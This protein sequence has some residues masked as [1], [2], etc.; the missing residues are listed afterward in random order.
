[1]RQEQQPAAVSFPKQLAALCLAASV[2][3]AA[4]SHER[5][6]GG[7]IA[8]SRPQS[9][10]VSV[11]SA[12]ANANPSARAGVMRDAERTGAEGYDRIEENGFT[13]VARAPLSTFS[14]DVD[15]ASYS[16]TRRFLTQ[17]QLPPADA[18]RVEEFINYF[19]YDYPQPQGGQPFSVS[20]E[21]ADCPW[22]PQHKLVQIGLQG[23]RVAAEDL[24]PSNLVFL[25]DVS[26]SMNHPNRL[27]LVKS[28]LRLLAEQ[29]SAR[30]RVAMVVYAGS[31]GLVLP[32]TP[33]DR[34]GE[35]LSAIDQLEAGGSTNG[36]EG[37]RLAYRVA[38]E[39]F[40]QGGINRVILATDGDFNVGVTSDDEL[41]RLVEERRQGGVSLSVL[42]YGMGNL[43]DS[44]MEKLADKGDG[45]YA[46][47]DTLAEARKVLG[48]Q[49]G[50]TLYTI[51]KDV[52]IQVEFNPR[53]VAGYRL[54][55]YE[56][57]LLRD[58]DFNDDGVDAGEIGAGHTV[59]ALYEIVPAGQRVGRGV[60]PLKY[61]KGGEPST[62]AGG[63]ELLT[64]KLRYKEPEQRDSKLLSTAVVDTRASHRNASDNFKFAA[65]VA[66]F[67][68]LLRD[69]PHKGEATYGHAL[70]LARA[71]T[72]ADLRGHRTEFVR[73]VETAR[74]LDAGR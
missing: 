57:R 44:R 32:S 29:L 45:N 19:S 49:M 7:E 35:I 17:G 28:S 51:A 14:I 66:E 72:G 37:L 25:I 34:T 60:D 31:S 70:E 71:A 36:G 6:G 61:Q 58:E 3:F 30:D 9:G 62:A 39:N 68:M 56:N 13:Q 8:A 38:Q 4:C 12:N 47:V 64:V 73:L 18:V 23:R 48:E 15:T 41:V 33:G 2:L 24:P 42:G 67:G 53:R 46:Y 21:A 69:S 55:G 63:G 40:R 59:T 16:N 26:G 22:N 52:K 65:A 1:M 10:T 11:G 74:S 43:K 20:A 54:V 27:P 50:G 5:N